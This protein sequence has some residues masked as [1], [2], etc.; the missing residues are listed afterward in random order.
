MKTL[1]NVT[2]RATHSGK[3]WAIDVPEIPGLFSQTRRLDQIEAM[4]KDAAKMLDYNIESI[5][6]EP[7]H[8][9][10]HKQKPKC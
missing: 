1:T 3:W 9:F 8:Q 10:L 6:V 2:A 7:V 5:T 4:V